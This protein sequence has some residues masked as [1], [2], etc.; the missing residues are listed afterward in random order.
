MAEACK[1]GQFVWTLPTF[2]KCSSLASKSR[3][4]NSPWP[5]GG[6]QCLLTGLHVKISL[7]QK[8]RKVENPLKHKID[9]IP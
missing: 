4:Q 1:F 6:P 2:S 7:I 3:V 9:L 8:P 5:E